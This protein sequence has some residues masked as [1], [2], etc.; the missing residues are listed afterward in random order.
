VVLLLAW[1][2][3]GITHFFVRV[4][5]QAWLIS[6]IASGIAYVALVVVFQPKGLENE[7]FG[8][9]VIFAALF[10]AGASL[11]MGAPIVV[12]RRVHAAAPPRHD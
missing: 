11:I 10:G 1:V 4:F 2:I 12:Y 9:G 3:S 5:W 6:A 8:V 7:M